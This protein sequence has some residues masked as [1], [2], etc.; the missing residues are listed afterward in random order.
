MS[1]VDASS[2][3]AQMHEQAM[4]AQQAAEETPA[5]KQIQ[6]R[7]PIGSWFFIPTGKQLAQ[8]TEVK[9]SADGPAIKTEHAGMYIIEEDGVVPATPEQIH[10]W[11]TDGRLQE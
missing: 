7:F 5:F 4:K 2:S 8:V 6:E 11:T 9:M 1:E 3:Y 10:Q